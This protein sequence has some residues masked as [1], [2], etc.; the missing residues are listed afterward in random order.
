MYF[1]GSYGIKIERNSLKWFNFKGKKENP[2][3]WNIILHKG[4]K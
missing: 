3:K 2:A 1:L 4:E